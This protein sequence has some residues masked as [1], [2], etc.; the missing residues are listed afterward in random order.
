M[1]V[2]FVPPSKTYLALAAP[3]LLTQCAQYLGTTILHKVA[4]YFGTNFSHKVADLK[5]SFMCII[6]T[7]LCNALCKVVP[8]Q[9]ISGFC[10]LCGVNVVLY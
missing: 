2:Q 9:L 5:Y 6:F 4:E 10:E 7:F 1:C 8:L 3:C